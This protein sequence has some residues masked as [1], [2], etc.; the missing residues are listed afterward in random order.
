MLTLGLSMAQIFV[1]VQAAA[2]ATITPAATGR[3]ST[4]FNAM[5]QLGGAIGVAIL[6]TVIVSV[7]PV[8]LVA[9]Q[10]VANL[11]AYRAA[12]LVAA[13][14]CCCA[15]PFSLSIHDADAA[16]TIPGRKGQQAAEAEAPRAA[17]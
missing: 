16:S 15:L 8:H 7:G 12:F 1:P 14:L 10:E 13:A 4:L 11:T 6:T 5:R 17:A 2:F 9:G 3:A